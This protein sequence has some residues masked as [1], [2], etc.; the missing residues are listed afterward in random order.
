MAPSVKSK[1]PPGPNALHYGWM[2]FQERF[3]F[4]RLARR[5]VKKY[6]DIVHV[7]MGTRHHYFINDPDYIEKILIAGYNIR[8][9]RPTPLRYPLGNGL[10]M[11]QGECHKEMRRR[12]APFFQKNAIV[13]KSDMVVEI[14][15]QF[16][17]QWKEGEVR[18]VVYEMNHLVLG[19]IIRILFGPQLKDEQTIKKLGEAINILFKYSHQNLISHVYLWLSRDIPFVGKYT[20]PARALQFVDDIIYQQI[21]ERRSRKDFDGPDFLSSLL[22]MQASGDNAGK[23]S[24]RQIRDELFT[25][26][27]AGHETTAITLSWTLLLL[28]QNP[29][30]E[31]KLHEELDRVLAGRLPC[32]EDIPNL[33]Y[34]RMVI[35]E[36]MRVYPAVWTIGRAPA[37]DGV[38]VGE[39]YLSRKSMVLLSPYITQRDERFFPDPEH[40]DP[41]RW[42]PEEQAKRHKYCYFPFAGGNR[43]C[44][45]E[46]LFWME[47]MLILSSILSKWRFELVPGH[48]I[49]MESMISLK[50]RYGVKMILRSRGG[51]TNKEFCSSPLIQGQST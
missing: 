31:S 1:Y 34:L 26:F 42:T 25:I 41:E 49:E 8:V 37:N 23:Y 17:R 14:S 12:T 51:N 40:F 39:Y 45:G 32:M 10:I 13:D 24:D 4:L 47:S 21:E 11:A 7:Q 46:H 29:E 50:P 30:T 19:I 15:E 2:Y 18:D 44:V 36:S 22:R 38:Q 33:Q 9:S 3:D 35:L 6:G 27:F 48:P 16:C 20:R 5:L 28:F 43:K